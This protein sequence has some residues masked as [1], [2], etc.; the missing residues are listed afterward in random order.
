MT[1][2][3]GLM[4]KKSKLQTVLDAAWRMIAPPP[5]ETV[6]E[7]SES[8]VIV[9]FG[10]MQGRFKMSRTT[11]LKQPMDVMSVSDPTQ[12][13]VCMFPAQCGKTTILINTICYIID[14][15][16]AETLVIMPSESLGEAFS[17]ERLSK[18]FA[19]MPSIRSKLASSKGRSS[20]NT[21]LKK[22]FAGGMLAIVGTGSSVNL[23]SRPIRFVL[24]DEIDKY[25]KNRQGDPLNQGIKR[26]QTFQERKKILKVST[27]TIE[28]HGA[29]DAYHKCEVQWERHLVCEECG[30]S[31]FPKFNNLRWE[32]NEHDAVINI[33]YRC[34]HCDHHHPAHRQRVLKKRGVW[35]KTKGELPAKSQGFWMN[36]LASSLATWEETITEF[37]K[38]K[39]SQAKLRQFYNE[40]LAETFKD[41]G[42][43]P[44][45]EAVR[46]MKTAIEAGIVPKD[47][48]C[49]TCA[50]DVQGDRLEYEVRAWGKD[51]GSWQ[52]KH[53]QIWGNI[54]DDEVWQQADN[55]ITAQYDGIPISLT[56]IDSG[57]TRAKDQSL[58]YTS[59]VYDFCRT[60]ASMKVYPV[61][62]YAT[63]QKTVAR[64]KVETSHDG[65]VSRL[66]LYRCSTNVLKGQVHSRLE[67]DID[68]HKSFKLNRDTTDEYCE[69]L[70]NEQFVEVKEGVFEWK[71]FGRNEAL[72]LAVYNTAA[73]YILN[74]P[75]MKERK[76]TQSNTKP[77]SERKSGWDAF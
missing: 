13:L 8:T 36:Q 21:I 26:T 69:Q 65:K 39:D 22:S 60:R 62:G 37:Y 61:K 67:M 66:T 57:G 25:E 27:P 73:A 19:E 55:V 18:T 72:D 32:K 71:A 52:V 28:K 23:S 6:S 43:A 50:F 51:M 44:K 31:S 59:L 45:A 64:S 35:I 20:E 3:A 47:A 48:F 14:R 54:Y 49:L 68:N 24:A 2:S 7:Y 5:K 29:H 34:E 56:L 17:K 74:V 40:C 63:Q 33:T 46:Q 53:G 75:S 1:Y 15:V 16:P 4:T 41:L 76:R 77:T 9:P 38:S 30:E 10:A 58:S 11:H 12:E 70:V 42:K